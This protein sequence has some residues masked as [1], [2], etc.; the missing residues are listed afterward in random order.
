MDVA[1]GRRPNNYLP[2]S[3]YGLREMHVANGRRP[4]NYLPTSIYS[5][6]EMDVATKLTKM[7]SHN[8]LNKLF[9]KKIATS[10]NPVK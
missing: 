5:L 1:N 10:S 2:T 7:I 3:I 6:R 4:N 8:Y 9:K